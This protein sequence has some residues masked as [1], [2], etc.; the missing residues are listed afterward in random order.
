VFPGLLVLLARFSYTMY[1]ALAFWCDS[2]IQCAPL[3]YSGSILVC[4]VPHSRILVRFSYRMCPTLAF[5]FDS[6]MR[7]ALLRA[8][9]CCARLRSWLWPWLCTR[10][11]LLRARTSAPGSGPSSARAPPCCARSPP[12]LALTLALALRARASL[13]RAH[14]SLLRGRLRSCLCS[15]P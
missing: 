1:H 15:W 3:F 14:A 13:L 2:R 6:P 5:W 9:P 10:T 12:L 11:S 7:C 4:D 8:P